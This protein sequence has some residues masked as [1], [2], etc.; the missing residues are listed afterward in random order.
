MPRQDE[1]PEVPAGKGGSGKQG[2]PKEHGKVG[3]EVKGQ[4]GKEEGIGGEYKEP[5][6]GEGQ[7]WKG[8]GLG[9]GIR[10]WPYSALEKALY[11]ILAKGGK[12]GCTVVAQDGW[13]K[14]QD[15]VQELV[16]RESEIWEQIRN[17]R[18]GWHKFV[19]SSYKSGEVW[20]G[21][22]EDPFKEGRFEFFPDAEEESEDG[23][24]VVEGG[25]FD[26]GEKKEDSDAW[27]DWAVEGQGGSTGSGPKEAGKGKPKEDRE[28]ETKGEGGEEP[29][30]R[31]GVSRKG[32]GAEGK[33][34]KRRSRSPS[35]VPADEE[36]SKKGKG[37]GKA[38]KQVA[39]FNAEKINELR[40]KLQIARKEYRAKK[41][42]IRKLE[43]GE[44][45]SGE[46]SSEEESVPSA[47]GVQGEG[48]ASSDKKG[49]G[50]GKEEK[51]SEKK[52]D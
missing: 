17:P 19:A 25:L 36:F 46:D 32:K 40:S 35:I 28:D 11:R 37:R 41:G 23:R 45:R 43:Q 38:K 47:G 30:K 27:G 29:K 3:R 13:A 14:M 20:V 26:G 39:G 7:G 6:K 5:A 22:V 1:V 18:D 49:V 50:E 10:P 8:G 24:S 4:K 51:G 34:L 42:E 15:L 12:P 52:E 31:K 48:A 2:S 44:A 9:K 16:C 21:F 33:R